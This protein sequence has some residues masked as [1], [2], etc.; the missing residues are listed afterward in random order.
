[1][2]RWDGIEHGARNLPT[3]SDRNQPHRGITEVTMIRTS[4]TKYASGL[5]A[6]IVPMAVLVCLSS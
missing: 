2:G 1:V 4:D 6:T 3:K 5:V